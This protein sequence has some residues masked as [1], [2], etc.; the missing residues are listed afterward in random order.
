MLHFVM[1]SAPSIH[2][3]NES[4]YGSTHV[5]PNTTTS[6]IQIVA[7]H[8]AIETVDSFEDLSHSTT[9]TC[10]AS[11]L[12]SGMTNRVDVSMNDSHNML[13]QE[14]FHFLSRLL[15]HFLGLFS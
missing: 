13:A 11:L 7:Q 1:F 12:P 3:N 14:K 2:S 6:D 4:V 9:V 8:S 5:L 10:Y 15:R